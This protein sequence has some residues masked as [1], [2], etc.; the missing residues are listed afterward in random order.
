MMGKW[1]KQE[2]E[3]EEHTLVPRHPGC[4]F[5]VGDPCYSPARVAPLR[6]RSVSPAAN[7]HALVSAPL[8]SNLTV[9][10][11]CPTGPGEREAGVSTMLLRGCCRV[12]LV[13]SPRGTRDRA[14]PPREP[15]PSPQAPA[16]GLLSQASS[17]SH[18]WR[19]VCGL[20]SRQT[21][22]PSVLL[23]VPSHPPQCTLRPVVSPQSWRMPGFL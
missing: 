21:P 22:G 11:S 15:L 13:T 9:A 2:E 18:P 17:E 4:L 23:H 19:L 7:K 14:A 8:G 16:Q 12:S 1:E 3:E 10:S 6:A 20:L 5:A